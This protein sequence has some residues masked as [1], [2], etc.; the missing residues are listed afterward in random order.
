MAKIEVKSDVTGVV[1]KILVAAG[2]SLSEDDQIILVESMKMEVPI[3]APED[4]MLVE[5]LVGE[6]DAV[7]EGDVIALME[8]ELSAT[9]S[10]I[11]AKPE[12]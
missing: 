12:E 4:G 2:T 10:S 6:G 3:I 7:A 8:E 11:E 9:P 5:I 1:W